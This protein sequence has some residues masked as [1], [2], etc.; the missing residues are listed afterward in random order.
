MTREQ[1]FTDFMARR[2]RRIYPAFLM[3][4]AVYCA[5]SFVFPRESRIPHDAPLGYL[6]ANLLLPGLFPIRPMITVAWSRWRHGAQR[7]AARM[8]T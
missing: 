1:H 2:I 5:L 4:F 8:S 3:V 6:A 7:P